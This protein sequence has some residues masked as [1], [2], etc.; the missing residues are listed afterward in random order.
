MKRIAIVLFLLMAV[1][2]SAFSQWQFSRLFPLAGD[3]S[4]VNDI[5]GLAVSPDGKVWVQRNG[6]NTRDS[7][8]I[9]DYLV[10]KTNGQDSILISRYDIV[11]ALYV[12]NPN[13]TQA[14]FSPIFAVSIGGKMD[15]LGGRRVRGTVANNP[16]QGL[17]YDASASAPAGSAKS[18]IG[19]LADHQGNILACYGGDMYRINYL[20]V[21]QN[22]L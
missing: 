2:G 20:T 22:W 7:I 5:H 15:T 10:K 13:G 1:A 8:L 3:T 14:S 16:G 21:G 9:P 11:R 4:Q 19:I 18:G 6:R 12:Y 17:R